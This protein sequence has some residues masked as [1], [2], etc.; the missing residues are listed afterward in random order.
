MKNSENLF[1]SPKFDSEFWLAIAVLTIAFVLLSTAGCS[2]QIPNTRVCGVAGIFQAGAECVWTLSDDKE[3]LDAEAFVDFL[4]P[5]GPRPDPKNP[6]LTLP[7]RGAALCTSEE[8][9][10]KTKTVLE[11]LCERAGARCT[12]EMRHQMEQVSR[13][14]ESL[15]LHPLIQKPK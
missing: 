5:Q 9:Y 7:A 8:D 14:V 11:Q 15:Q 13:R 4:E 2:T 1:D 12:R 3:S 10:T 6:G